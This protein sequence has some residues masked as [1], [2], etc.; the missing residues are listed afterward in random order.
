MNWIISANGK[1]Y[2]HAAAFQKFGE[3]DWRQHAN[4]AIGDIVYIYCTRPLSRIMFKTVVVEEG[5]SSNN[6]IDD[7]EFWHIEDEYEKALKGKYARLKLVDQ[8]DSQYLSLE[9][10]KI[11]G[12]KAAPQGPVKAK[13]E[14][15]L[16]IEKYMNDYE[17]DGIFPDSD[18]NFGDSE[19]DCVQ[20]LVNK[21]ER[22]SIARKKCIEHHGLTCK[23]CG[24]NFEQKYGEIGEGF[25]HIHHIK[26]LNQI[27]K[28]Y[29]VDYKNDLIPV[30]PNC[31]AMLHRKLNNEYL[32]IEDLKMKVEI[33]NE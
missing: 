10:L 18:L 3:L 17:S 32:S 25:I 15:T 4:Y 29:V 24:M 9:H 20:V 21:Y 22:S 23:I 13:D 16:Y 31:H 2:D 5:K 26:P 11:H 8:V 30:C 14:L 33:K 12:L 6:I 1:M 28:S 27:G 7:R 19:G